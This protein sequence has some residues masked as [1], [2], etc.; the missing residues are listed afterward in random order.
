MPLPDSAPN[1]RRPAVK[2]EVYAALLGWIVEGTLGPGERVRDKELAEALGVSRT[3]VREALQRLEDVGLVETSASRWTRVAPLDVAQAE[4]VYPVVWA[5]EA[6]AV[7]LAGRRLTDGDLGAM[8]GANA[9]LE[10]DLEAGDALG[11]SRA[12]RDFHDVF[13]ACS[14]NREL[15]KILDDLKVKIRRLEIAYFGGRALAEH[16]VA[17]H[18]LILGALRSGDPERAA[19]GVKKNWEASL[20][21]FREFRERAGGA[22]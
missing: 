13:V 4:E 12:D 20:K 8:E 18:R 22:A 15:A 3:P 10:R 19:E 2:D 16:S 1:L 9:R 7:T 6:L 11:A 17:E 21:R 5:L 14:L